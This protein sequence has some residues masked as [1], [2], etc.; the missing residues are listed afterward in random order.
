MIVDSF[1]FAQSQ[2]SEQGLLND[3]PLPIGQLPASKA[4]E[5]HLCLFNTEVQSLEGWLDDAAHNSRFGINALIPTD[6]KQREIWSSYTSA[7]TAFVVHPYLQEID[8]NGLLKI[9]QFLQSGAL[10]ER[11]VFV[12]T[13][14]GSQRIYDIE[15]LK[16]AQ[17]IASWIDSPVILAH[18]GGA[19]II[20]ALLLA[21]AYPHIYLETSFSLAYW[22]GSSV[23]QDIAF[24]MKKLG[25]KR[26][27]YGSDAPYCSEAAALQAHQLFFEKFG[28]D[29]NF[30]EWVQGLSAKQIL[31]TMR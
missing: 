8:A 25:A 2:P 22:Q 6:E 1:C 28:F 29:D 27:L 13:A 23:E 7:F 16:V 18:C 21:D 24:A 20:D 9:K 30:Q 4:T 5:R 19:K 11:P 10:N 17:K 14:I 3:M 12:C 26:W 31:S 15:P